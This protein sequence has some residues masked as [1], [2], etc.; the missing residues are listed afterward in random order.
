MSNDDISIQHM[1]ID[2]DIDDDIDVTEWKEPVR[3]VPSTSREQEG[4]LFIFI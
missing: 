4:R 1:K 3:S 2:D